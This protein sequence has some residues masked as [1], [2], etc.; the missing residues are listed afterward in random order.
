MCLTDNAVTRKERRFW[1]QFLPRVRDYTY[2]TSF[3][4]PG[5]LVLGAE[6]WVEDLMNVRWL[7]P[8]ELVIEADNVLHLRTSSP[9]FGLICRSNTRVSKPHDKALH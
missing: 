1:I 3:T 9:V 2:F 5:G 7:L 8:R 4:N 6:L